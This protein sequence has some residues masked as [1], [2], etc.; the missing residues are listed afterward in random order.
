MEIVSEHHTIQIC[1]SCILS[2]P[3]K[4]ALWRAITLNN[5]PKPAQDETCYHGNDY[6]R[7]VDRQSVIGK[8]L[9][10]DRVR[11]RDRKGW[12]EREINY[13]SSS[14]RK[15][16]PIK[17]HLSGIYNYIMMHPLPHQVNWQLFLLA[18]IV[19]PFSSLSLSQ[20]KGRKVFFKSWIAPFPVA[21]ARIEPCTYN[22][23]FT[24]LYFY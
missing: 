15:D 20:T 4:T 19:T 23:P 22:I 5:R 12:K 2:H 9:M 7:F 8:R 6:D 1:V 17:A 3:L 14:G 18:P 11:Q 16:S 13:Q 21:N 10:V 24:I